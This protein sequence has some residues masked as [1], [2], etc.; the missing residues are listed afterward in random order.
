MKILTIGQDNFSIPNM[1]GYEIDCYIPIDNLPAVIKYVQQS[2][3]D[4][5][6]IQAE[7]PATES[8]LYGGLEL[9]IWLRIKGVNTHIVLVSFFSLEALMK[10][11]KNA[12]ILGAEGTTFCQMPFLPSS[13]ELIELSKEPSKDDNLKTYLSSIFDIVHFRHAYANAWGLQRLVEVYNKIFYNDKFKI[14][15]TN[16]SK[17]LNY[18]IGEFLYKKN[19]S[20]ITGFNNSDIVRFRNYIW[21]YN[22]LNILYIDDK[23]DQ[24]WL[25][26]LKHLFNDTVTFCSLDLTATTVT[27]LYSQ[28][29]N[30]NQNKKI[31]FI[32]SDLRL[33]AFEDIVTDYDQLVS[34]KLMKFIF[35]KRENNRLKY[36][37]LNYML[38]T[39]SNQLLNYKTTLENNRYTPSTLFIKE[40]L[41]IQNRDNQ[42]Y[43]NFLNLLKSL[44]KIA[45][46]KHRK[47]GDEVEGFDDEEEKKIDDFISKNKSNKWGKSLN[48]FER[49]FDKF[50]YVILDSNMYIRDV[51]LLPLTGHKNIVLTYP[52]YK[53]LERIAF[54]RE[55]SLR[56]YL[57]NYFI[58]A[59]VGKESKI[60]L[61]NQDIEFID[62]K[63]NEGEGLADIA[64][65]YFL[66]TIKEISTDRNNQVLFI[67]N[68]I[69]EKNGRIPPYYQVENWVNSQKIANV[70]VYT[71]FGNQFG[72]M[73]F[74][75]RLDRFISVNENPKL[76]ANNSLSMSVKELTKVKW[77]DCVLS[78]N[79]EK[80]TANIDGNQFVAKIG[81]SHQPGFKTVFE[82]LSKTEEEF[83]I[84]PDGFI[85]NI[86]GW[87]STA[88]KL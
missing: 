77:K 25:S 76:K 63:F 14:T 88:N 55:S 68:D 27:D 41:D 50:T 4:I 60:G 58:F 12:F 9:L 15:P 59:N 16:E 72:K 24:G 52:V 37:K 38:F 22:R 18:N 86:S 80:I 53:E 82:K 42:Q 33:Y 29:E 6:F 48:E 56:V 47:K 35:D 39:A 17:S 65:S 46:E 84:Q 61:S 23:A 20:N 3:A 79:C 71:F 30:L 49:V 70:F 57:A 31:D 11:T 45:N 36:P 83:E 51:P 40:G 32:I 73:V 44:N 87:K 8:D 78:I 66:K 28:F 54:S 2:N 5:I 21:K 43:Q 74:D 75:E 34:I 7:Q 19:D 26:F 62:H 67:T 81:K 10:N 64:D 13:A 1:D 85:H 69:T